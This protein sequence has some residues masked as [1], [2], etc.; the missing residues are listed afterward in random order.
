[1]SLAVL[2]CPRPGPAG[3]TVI[4]RACRYLQ[5]C[6]PAVSGQRGHDATFRVACVLVHGFA[7]PAG[8]ALNVLREWNRACQPPWSESELAHK[9]NSALAAP[10]QKVPGYLLGEGG[11]GGR[12]QRWPGVGMTAA[13]S[14]SR[15]GTLPRVRKVAFDPNTAKRVAAR[16][17]AVDEAFVKARSPVCPET[18]TPASF[19][20]RLYRPGEMVL[21]F[22]VFESQGRHLCECDEPPYDVECLDHLVHGCRD[23]VWFLCNPVDG[24]WHPNPR[25]GGKRSRRSEES[26]TAWRY[27]VLES[28]KTDARDWLA[29]MVQLPLRIAAIYSSGGR[30]IHA[31]V[32]VDASD[33]ADWDAKAR[34]LKPLMTILGA[35]P[36]SITAVRLTRLPG[37]YRGE[38]GPPGR[39]EPLIRKRWVDEPLEFDAAGDPIWAPSEPE[40]AL[41]Q[42]L[43]TNGNLQELLY[44]NPTPDITPIRHR[45]TR[46]QVYEQWLARV[47][48]ERKEAA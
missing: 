12:D 6:A 35:D 33:K 27:L 4:E 8:D 39:K 14:P 31:L 40:G 10:P 25:L 11:W 29:V 41:P 1:M 9:I 18:Q 23:G 42:N 46:Q 45:P 34:R 47:R 44:L 3:N 37:C 13:L 38:D 19:L 22:D 2:M 16:A 7:L 26:V 32:R 17:P 36:G 21:V 48:A 28:D 15:F 30:S 43:W 24:K 20:Q 5:K